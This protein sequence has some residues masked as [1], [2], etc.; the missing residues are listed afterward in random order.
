MSKITSSKYQWLVLVLTVG[1][2][3]YFCFGAAPQR[4]STDDPRPVL[5][6]H[7]LSSDVTSWK[8]LPA[9]LEDEGHG[10]Y[11]LNFN[12][13]SWLPF[14]Q[15]SKM[16][17]NEI[18]AVVALKIAEI[19]EYTGC[20]KVDVIAHSIG[21][22]AVRA[23][24]AGWGARVD[25]QCGYKND[26]SRIVYLATPHYGLN[27]TSAQL[28]KFLQE[29]DYGDFKPS[30]SYLSD[31]LS[32]AS[33]ELLD[34]HDFF[35]EK[36]ESLG[37]QELTISSEADTMVKDY[38]ANLDGLQSDPLA[39]A[40][41]EGSNH[42]HLIKFKH[43]YSAYLGRPDRTLLGVGSK[44]HP[45]Y[46]IATSYFE[47]GT[48]WTKYQTV[49]NKETSLLMLRF[50]AGGGINLKDLNPNKVSL[51]KMMAGGKCKNVK[52]EYNSN[53]G[54]F[55]TVGLQSGKFKLIVPYRKD[56][57]HAF[58]FLM[59]IAGGAVSFLN[60]D[61]ENPPP[62]PD[63][64]DLPGGILV[65]PEDL[66]NIVKNYNTIRNFV[67]ATYPKE[68]RAWKSGSEISTLT[69]YVR[70][71]IISLYPNKLLHTPDDPDVEIDKLRLKGG[72]VVDFV[73]GSTDPG[74]FLNKLQWLPIK[75]NEADPEN[76]PELVHNLVTLTEFA[77]VLFDE[78]LDQPQNE[79]T[80]RKMCKKLRNAIIE[81]Y[82]DVYR[83]AYPS[84]PG[85][86]LDILF[87]KEDEKWV[88]FFI[89]Y[90]NGNPIPRNHLNWSV[91]DPEPEDGGGGG[92]GGGGGDYPSEAPAD[93]YN[94]ETLRIFVLWY[95]RGEAYA[96]K[97]PDMKAICRRVRDKLA[98][99]YSN[100]ERV[101]DQKERFGYSAPDH[102][103]S[104][105]IYLVRQNIVIDFC[106]A[107]SSGGK[108]INKIAW[109]QVGT[110]W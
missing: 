43:A 103:H 35:A 32:V 47:G 72:R 17:F 101:N 55:Y 34:L 93:V 15:R 78:K 13:W 105:A 65:Y 52:L 83:L 56:N 27:V 64:I 46:G 9:Y 81:Q 40:A 38:L 2:L 108:L 22:I 96:Y 60:F 74:I 12:A 92:G 106:T 3:S 102:S 39:P 98:S 110:P 107:S 42:I 37:I 70:D 58:R 25:N 7:G 30:A 33:D 26:I 45:L 66:P 90:A 76:Y 91:R 49:V 80:L 73:S 100:I 77:E 4:A 36:G 48:G 8:N 62:D 1:V 109:G 97:S 84:S 20:E 54:I 59:D 16:S 87:R 29:T 18:A 50:A 51:K 89:N 21:G 5:L 69:R 19:K 95:L 53:S 6:I 14:A 75:A 85:K 57:D 28:V 94:K 23:Y 63:L 99:K 71:A 31:V 11:P 79:L 41:V 67:L 44:D 24:V 61:A 86:A 82:P 88:D 68:A 10:V 104:D